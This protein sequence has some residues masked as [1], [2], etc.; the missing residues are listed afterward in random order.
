MPIFGVAKVCL[1]GPCSA[2]VSNLSIP[3]SA[4]GQGG[5]QTLTGAVNLTVIGAPWT[6]GTAAV[7]AITRMGSAH[8]PA[9][10]TSSTFAPGGR[11]QLVTPIVV[12]S[13]VAALTPLP[14]FATVTLQF[15]PEPTTLAL[16]G[17]GVALL[18][19]AGRERHG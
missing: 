12:H 11:L 16:L 10:G 19:L 7:G 9:S 15:I 8:G 4:V 18:G 3:L 13:H 17:S 1:F 14:G 5:Y 2:A 6:I